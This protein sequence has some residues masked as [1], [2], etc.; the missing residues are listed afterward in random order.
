MAYT[1]DLNRL[2][3]SESLEFIARQV[4]EGFIVGLHKSPFHGFS[5]EF[6]E[7]RLYNAGE[8]IKHIDWKLYGRTDKLFVKRYEEET[9]LRCQIVMDISS[10][11]Y[12]PVKDKLS[13]DNPNKITFSVY[14]AAALIHLLK[15]QRDAFGLS[16]FSDAV[17]EHTPVKSS[18]VH[19]KF[20]YSKLENLLTPLPVDKRKKTAATGALH[21]IAE[22]IH[23]RSLVIIF[24]DMLDNQASEELLFSSLQ[25]LK[26]NKHEVILFHVNDKNKEIDFDFENRPYKFIDME[27]GQ[28]VKITPS[29]VREMYVQNA[30]R[31]KE[32]LKLKCG[33]YKIDFIEA[34]INKGFDQILLPY[35]LK[36]EKLY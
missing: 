18:S 33:Q 10:S 7:H 25:H 19:Q 6:A 15:K 13:L 22:K 8:S 4:V 30:R 26:H 3:K 16:L 24:S 27:G 32:N 36:R 11:M 23:K 12:F 14:A 34:D 20:L 17:E 2:Q 28:E 21:E 29:E 31:F 1:L 9:N 35:L 5:V